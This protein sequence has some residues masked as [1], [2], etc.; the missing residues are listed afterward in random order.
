MYMKQNKR[1]DI[2]LNKYYMVFNV[3]YSDFVFDGLLDTQ[4]TQISW[5]V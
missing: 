4:T 3:F 2:Q 1:L 5:I